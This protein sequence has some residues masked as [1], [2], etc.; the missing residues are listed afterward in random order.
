[1][2]VSRVAEADRTP[3]ERMTLKA[4]DADVYLDN[5]E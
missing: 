5:L 4:E 3:E 2:K 1:M